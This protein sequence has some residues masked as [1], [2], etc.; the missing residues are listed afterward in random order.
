MVTWENYE[1]FILLYVDGELNEGEK[2]ELLEFAKMHPEVQE[3]VKAYEAVVLK[4]DTSEVYPAKETLLKPVPAGKVIS[5]NRWWAYGAAAGVLLLVGIMTARLINQPADPIATQPALAVKEEVKKTE[6]KQTVSEEVSQSPAI[7][8]PANHQE[9][10]PSVAKKS[11][12]HSNTDHFVKE[13]AAFQK[14]AP[15]ASTIKPGLPEMVANTPEQI[16]TEPVRLPEAEAEPGARKKEG[17]IAWLPV[18][19]EKKEGLRNLKD[20]VDNRLD[21]ARKLKENLK[22]TEFALKLGSKELFVINF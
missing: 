11:S 20:N 7:K 22:E 12:V 17:F 3:E 8:K 9:S 4:P 13:E 14:M 2:Q 5:L 16:A 10:S 1:E 15:I 6:P 18:N 21:Q 19:E